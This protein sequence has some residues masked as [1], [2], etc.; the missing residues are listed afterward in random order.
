MYLGEFE[1][2]KEWEG[3]CMYGDKDK[4]F[5]VKMI[6]KYLEIMT[7]FIEIVICLFYSLSL[8]FYWKLC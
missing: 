5:Y 8:S 7:V 1:F 2:I 3:L 6:R 4:Y